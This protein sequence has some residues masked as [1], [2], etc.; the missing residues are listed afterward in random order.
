MSELVVGPVDDS[1]HLP[2]QPHL[3]AKRSRDG[4][5]CAAFTADCASHMRWTMR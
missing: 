2:L 1:A 5:T 3:N 4:R